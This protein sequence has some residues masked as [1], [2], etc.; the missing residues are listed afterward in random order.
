MRW[1]L[2]T[3]T[4]VFA[5]AFAIHLADHAIRGPAVVQPMVLW[6]GVLQG[7]FAVIVLT[8][9]LREYPAAA[10][11][12]MV[13]GFGSALLFTSAHLLPHWGPNSD[14][15]IYPA[16]GAGVT[17]F[18]WVTAVLEVGAALVLGAAAVRTQRSQRAGAA[19]QTQVGTSDAPR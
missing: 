4:V 12:A 3:V 18:S 17:W 2:K 11:F 1:D 10:K 8:M 7:V 15:Y 5:I 9:V 16:P 14:S 6:G 19:P 13:L